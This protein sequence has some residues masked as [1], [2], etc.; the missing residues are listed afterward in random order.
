MKLKWT[1]ENSLS[2]SRILTFVMMVFAC[3][4]LFCIPVITE[5]YD[6][7]S[8][9]APIHI[10]LNIGL[11]L[12][13]FLGILALWELFRMF[14]NIRKK[15]VFVTE[16]VTIMRVISWCCF[17]VALIWVLLSYLRLMSM[18][19]AFTAAFAGIIIRVMKNLFAMAVEMREEND[20]TI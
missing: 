3:V 6:A 4:S 14:S 12:S 10:Y 19:V 8:D 16:N 18:F 1:A 5:W 17:G 9:Q 13:A 7:I 20:F 11:Y 2:L 15:L